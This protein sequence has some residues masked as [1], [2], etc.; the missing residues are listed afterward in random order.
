MLFSEIFNIT[1]GNGDDWFDTILDA[2]TKLFIDPFLLFQNTSPSFRGAHDKIIDFFNYAFKLAAESEPNQRNIKFRILKKMMRFSEVKEIC[3]GYASKSIDGAG[4]GPGFAEDIVNAIYE[5]IDMGIVSTSHFEDLGLFGRGI[6]R[7]RISDA[8]ANI[9]KSDLISYTQKI[10]EYHNI[11]T[12]NFVVEH[13]DFDGKRGRWIRKSELLP[14]NPYYTDRGIIL[15]PMSFLNDLPTIDPLD[16]LDFCWDNKNEEVRD[17]FSFDIKSNINRDDIIRM[18]KMRRD[19]VAEYE[20]KT[21]KYKAK[22]YDFEADP[23]G[24]YNWY[25]EARAFAESKPLT[26]DVSDIESFNNSLAIMIDQFVDFIE[27][28]SG[29]KLLWNDKG[30]P[31]SEEACQLLFT[32]IIKH[33]CRANGIDLSR[34]V[35]L[36]RGPVDFKFSSGYSKRTLLEVKLAKNSKFWH[37]MESQLVKYLEVEEIKTGYFLVV[38]YSD[39]DLKRIEDIEKRSYELV[40]KTGLDILPIVID[41]RIGKLS[42][43]KL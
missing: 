2:D 9:I 15:V 22:S 21:E 3:L 31:K 4:S 35:N 32:G 8:A 39:I 37:G 17:E 30:N 12:E 14:R 24:L 41:A 36:G 29:Y 11:P 43:S 20:K 26:L 40:Q 28:N 16:F 5:S 33:Y 13:A 18:A 42:A 38:C 25:K 7:D 6:G 34:E 19:W 27:N 23:L 10:C 1:I